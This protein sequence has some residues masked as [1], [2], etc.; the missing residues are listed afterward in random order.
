MAKEEKK[1]DAELRKGFEKAKTCPVA[2]EKKKP[3]GRCPV[4][5]LS[6]KGGPSVHTSDGSRKMLLY[7]ALGAAAIVGGYLL[8]KKL[9][10]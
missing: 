8:A 9:S 7:G 5:G 1:V 4:T 6:S 2:H 10:K 3:A